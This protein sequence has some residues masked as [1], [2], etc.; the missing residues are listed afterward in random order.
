[1]KRLHLI[2]SGEVQG[3]FF[4]D[5]VSKTANSLELTGW[6]RN[7]SDGTVEVIAEGSEDS[8]KE[9]LEKCRQG[10]A[11]ARVDKVDVKWE[12]AAEEFKEFS[13]IFK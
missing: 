6:A 4:R 3:V 11:A 2:I 9:L 8:L 13:I 7:N 5:Y 1:M 12:K 10:P